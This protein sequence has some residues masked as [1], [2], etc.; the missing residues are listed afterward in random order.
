MP[1]QLPGLPLGSCSGPKGASIG[2]FC[3]GRINLRSP[4]QPKVAKV[5]VHSSRWV[6]DR[7]SRTRHDR[8]S[9]QAKPYPC[10]CANVATCTPAPTLVHEGTNAQ[11]LNAH[12]P[13]AAHILCLRALA[14]LPM[15][16]LRRARKASCQT[17]HACAWLHANM[18]RY[19]C[20]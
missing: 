12:A 6:L 9:P 10:V 2:G 19:M 7:P 5:E 20:S 3:S 13:T 16:D 8:P 14:L 17:A 15:L 18:H 11:I 4:W 1:G